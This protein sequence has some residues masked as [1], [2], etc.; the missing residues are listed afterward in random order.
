MRKTN[1]K[2]L[3]KKAVEEI[4]DESILITI[5]SFMLGMLKS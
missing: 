2:A 1:Y 3:I 4:N 5:Y